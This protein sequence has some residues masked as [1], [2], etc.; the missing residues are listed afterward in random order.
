[1]KTRVLSLAGSRRVSQEDLKHKKDS[2]HICWLEDRGRLWKGPESNLQLAWLTVSKKTGTS[3]LSNH[4]ELDS[5]DS[6]NDPG[7]RYPS[8]SPFKNSAQS[9]P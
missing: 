3:G 4:K 2:V 8:E 5:A 9:T 7:S 6:L 1:M